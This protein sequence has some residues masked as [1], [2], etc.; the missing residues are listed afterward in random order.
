MSMDLTEQL[1]SGNVTYGDCYTAADEIATL[2]ARVEQ[3]EAALTVLRD[4][5]IQE[6]DGPN[7]LHLDGVAHEGPAVDWTFMIVRKVKEIARAA[8]QG[9]TND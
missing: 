9:P 7:I 1:R 5:P 2:R 3:L 8:I 6:D 4:L